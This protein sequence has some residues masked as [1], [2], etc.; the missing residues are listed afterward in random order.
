[1]QRLLLSLLFALFSQSALAIVSMQDIHL[2][3]P[4]EGFG[5]RIAFDLNSLSGNSNKEEYNVGGNLNYRSGKSTSI[6][7]LDTAY[8]ES[9]GVPYTN[10]S[11]GHL[12]EIYQ[13]TPLLAWEAFVQRESDVFARLS[14]RQLYGGGARFTFNPGD[15][16]LIYLGT[17]VFNESET[18]DNK[19]G[20][21]DSGKTDLVRG[22]L[23][24]VF[25]YILNDD[26]KLINSTYWQPALSDTA[27]WRLLES[28]A[29]SVSISKKLSLKMSLG[30]RNDSQP[31][32]KLGPVD[33]SFSSSLEYRF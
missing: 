20:T 27:D 10:R 3:P 8:G 21:T 13:S 19:A 15:H 26:L 14:L 33:R 28:L 12:R 2:H 31:P 22:N 16:S 30:Y 5:G 29:L 7:L 11:F 23:Y 17:G 9:L 4:G 24:L 25:K 32:Q 6:L 1:M 18:L